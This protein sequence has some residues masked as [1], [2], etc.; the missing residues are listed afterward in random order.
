MCI[1]ETDADAM[2]VE[3]PRERLQGVDSG[4][5]TPRSAGIHPVVL[6]VHPRELDG[7][8]SRGRRRR[9]G[10]SLGHGLCRFHERELFDLEALGGG[11]PST[12]GVKPA[13]LHDRP[14]ALL[15]KAVPVRRGHRLHPSLFRGQRGEAGSLFEED[16]VFLR[17]VRRIRC[18]MASVDRQ[19]A[20]KKRD[21]QNHAEP[22]RG[23]DRLTDGPMRECVHF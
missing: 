11:E 16:P 12:H 22:N 5:M 20:E 1:E 17:G 21:S 15:A 2:S 3:P 8:W 4:E 13:A 23:V 9:K 14:Y 7:T 18:S 10:F 19:R 6:R